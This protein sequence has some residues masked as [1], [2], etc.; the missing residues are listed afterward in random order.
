MSEIY[1]KFLDKNRKEMECHSLVDH[2][3]QKHAEK[4]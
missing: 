1:T 2:S 4:H 3:Y